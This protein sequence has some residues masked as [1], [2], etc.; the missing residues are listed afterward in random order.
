MKRGLGLGL[1]SLLLC[2]TAFTQA[3]PPQDV[4]QRAFKVEAKPEENLEKTPGLKERYALLIGISKYANPELSLNFAAADAQALY[5]VLTDP[6]IGAYKPENV[7]LLVDDQA[8]RKNI[9]SAMNTWLKNRVTADDSVVIFYSGH[10]ALGGASEAYWVT[11]DADAEDL[12]SSAVSNKD[13]SSAIAELPAKRKITFIDSCFSEATAKKY[14]ALVPTTIFEQFKGTGVVT[15]TASTGQQKSVEVGGHGAFTYHLLD[16]LQ[17]KADTNSNGVVELDE[18]WN[19]L[20]DR[21]QKTAADAGNRQTPVLMAERL[22]HGFPVTVNPTASAAPLLIKL[23]GMYSD[24]QITLDEMAEAEKVL[25][26]RQGNPELRNLYKGLAE[27]AINVQYFRQLKSVLTTGNAAATRG[28]GDAAPGA[29]PAS[30]A[31]AAPAGPGGSAGAGAATGAELEA[32]R[33]AEEI[34]TFDGWLRY[35]TQFP[36]GFL[37]G[38]VRSRLEEM[39]KK[40][41]EQAAYELARQADNEKTWRQFLSLHPSGPHAQ[42]AERRAAELRQMREGE[43]NA[44]RLAE[45]KNLASSWRRFLDEYPNGQ[46]AAIAEDRVATL[47]R[48]E[49]EKEDA[50]YARAMK[51]NRVEDWDLY[52]GNYVTGRYI[53]DAMKR[54]ADLIRKIEEDRAIKAENDLFASAVKGDSLES[55]GAYAAKYPKGPHIDEA[56]KRIDQ[57]K[58][59]QFADVMPVPGGQFSMGSDAK[60]ETK[61]MHR[62]DVDGFLMGRSEVTNAQYLKFVG[63]TN[64]RRPLDPSFLKNYMNQHPDLPALGVTYDDAMAYCKWLSEK[65]GAQVRLPT[66]AEWEYAAS[67]AKPGMMYP[68][69]SEQPR[70]KAR[71]K[72]NAPNG[73]KTVAATLFPP[74]A[75]GLL[76]MSGNAAEWVMDWYSETYY[77]QSPAKNPPGPAAGK[78]RVVRGGSWKSDAEDLLVTRR[79]KQM[80]STPSDETGFRIVIESIRK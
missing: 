25:M 73:P 23:K 48:A 68:W 35:L 63:E 13:I 27:K 12:A 19:Y 28:P 72:D 32:F 55:W 65:T 43:M 60:N 57:L 17:G 18:I 50:E 33:V 51:N 56:T 14:R 59:T 40:K 26:Q 1:L 5:K 11:Y 47:K 3:P 4:K 44:F 49:Q 70:T 66:E 58:W 41:A 42:E 21:V 46:F 6:E 9:V 7:R 76:N 67:G 62:V 69:G 77:R 71:Y 80:P 38:S 53:D 8:T 61:P 36:H 15:I 78:E 79:G 64:Y 52:I 10:G 22:E 75:F 20:N 34:G 2:G 29:P 30:A 74:T 16:G 31:G 45:S 54:R 24:S 39:D 37:A